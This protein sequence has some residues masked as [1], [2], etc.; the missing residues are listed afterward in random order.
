MSQ[1]ARLLAI[2]EALAARIAQLEEQKREHTDD[3]KS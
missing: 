2:L 1:D 3:W